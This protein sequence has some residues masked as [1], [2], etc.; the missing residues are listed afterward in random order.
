ME[1]NSAADVAT[2]FGLEPGAPWHRVEKAVFKGTDCGAW[3][4]FEFA[5]KEN[6]GSFLLVGSIV[7]G[8][9]VDCQTIRLKLPTTGEELGNALDAVEEEAAQIW[10][11]WNKEEEATWR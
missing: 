7:E 1:I 6:G 3:I 5:A 10:N 4:K 2:Y 11:E 8:S 9:H